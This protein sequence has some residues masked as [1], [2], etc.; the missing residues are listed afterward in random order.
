[1][2]FAHATGFGL[3]QDLAGTRRGEVDFAQH[4]RHPET[5]N[6]RGLHFARH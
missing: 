5:F 6:H 2:Q 1:M 4:K 3:D